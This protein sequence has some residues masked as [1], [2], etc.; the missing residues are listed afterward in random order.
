MSQ[1]TYFFTSG[2]LRDALDNGYFANLYPYLDYMPNYCWEL[3]NRSHD[4]DILDTAFYGDD[5]VVSIYGLYSTPMTATGYFL[6]QD[7]MDKLGL[8]K[9]GELKTYDDLHSVLAAFKTAYGPEGAYPMFIFS[10]FE[11]QR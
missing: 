1:G 4:S 10:T 3:G 6:R 11:L 8:G 9:A 5:E 7:W 2:T